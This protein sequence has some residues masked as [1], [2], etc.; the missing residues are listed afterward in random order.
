MRSSQSRLSIVHVNGELL[1][2]VFPMDHDHGK[3]MKRIFSM[4][5]DHGK[6]MKHI[7]LC[8]MIMASS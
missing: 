8:S 4:L 1:K 7:F 6:F 3:C 5:Y 2:H